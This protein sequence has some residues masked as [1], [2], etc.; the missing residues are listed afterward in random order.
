MRAPALYLA[1]LLLTLAWPSFADEPVQ[2]SPE[3]TW[4]RPVPLPSDL[5]VQPAI[6]GQRF[7]MVDRQV[8]LE[9]KQV[10]RFSRYMIDRITSYN[11]CYTKL[12]RPLHR[13]AYVFDPCIQTYSGANSRSKP[14]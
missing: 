7:L 14:C 12:L 10:T 1:C 9:A 4:L 5:M 13:V 3:P 2:F 8:N 11:V 6:D